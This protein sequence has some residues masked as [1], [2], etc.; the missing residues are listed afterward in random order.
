M[1]IVLLFL[2]VLVAGTHGASAEDVPFHLDHRDAGALEE[3]T[4]VLAEEVKLAARPHT[5]LL[6]DLVDNVV[7]M[8]ARGVELQR[9]PLRNWSAVSRE[10]MTGT[11]RLTARPSVVRRKIDPAAGAEQEPITLADMPGDYHLDFTPSLAIDVVP[12]PSDAP[13]RWSVLQVT[14]WGMSARSWLESFR[15]GSAPCPRLVLTLPEDRAQSLA[16]SL[17]DG[18]PLVI[19]RRSS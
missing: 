10:A 4:R 6:V 13:L 17:V 8:K 16:W 5:Y 15:P 2:S 1:T 12:P 18:M 19:R 9:L 14:L 3:A 11:F 7:I